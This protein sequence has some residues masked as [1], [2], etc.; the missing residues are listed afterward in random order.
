M[1]EHKHLTPIVEKYREYVAAEQSY[2]EAK[3]LLSEGGLDKDFKELAEE[4][5]K[6]SKENMEVYFEELKFF[7]SPVTLTM[8]KTL[9]LKFV[10][11][12]A[13]KRQPF[14]QTHL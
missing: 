6:E 10:V 13:V 7:F 3:A 12:Q 14:L 9:L 2:E 8:I 11:V 4:E 5:L 1:Q